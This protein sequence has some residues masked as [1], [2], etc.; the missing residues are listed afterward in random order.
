MVRVLPHQAFPLA[1]LVAEGQEGWVVG[2]RRAS[3]LKYPLNSIWQ[4][5]ECSKPQSVEKEQDQ[6]LF[7]VLKKKRYIPDIF[8][9]M[10]E[11]EPLK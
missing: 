5:L 3:I 8:T 2:D 6:L 11:E 9:V 7:F 10:K 4:P 1:N